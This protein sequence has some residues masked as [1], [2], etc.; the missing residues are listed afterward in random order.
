MAKTPPFTISLRSKWTWTE[1][2]LLNVLFAALRLV[3]AA[4]LWEKVDE[5]RFSR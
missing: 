3:L 4:K 5:W 2:R 1:D